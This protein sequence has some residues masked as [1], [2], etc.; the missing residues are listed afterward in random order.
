MAFPVQRVQLPE[1][2]QVPPPLMMSDPASFAHHT[3]TTRWPAVV[4]RIL[5]END[6]E[7]PTVARLQQLCRDLFSGTV[8]SLQDEDAPDW[9]DWEQDLLPYLGL[10]WAE[11]PWLFA[12][13]YFYRRILEAV[14]YFSG[15]V[16]PFAS[17]K[18]AAL[19]DAARAAAQPAAPVAQSL[20]GALWGNRADLSLNPEQLWRQES[21]A[22]VDRILADRILA[23]RILVDR[24]E[25][26][27]AY[28]QAPGGSSS[29]RIRI[30]IVA[31]NA[32]A[33]LLS[34]LALAASLLKARPDAQ[35]K[36]HLK[37]YP[38]FVSDATL[39]DAAQTLAAIADTPLGAEL[40]PHLSQGVLKLQD[41]PLWNRPLA[42]W[43][44][45]EPLSAIFKG[46]RLVIL[47]GDANYRRLLGDCQW[48][49]TA[50]F[51]RVSAYFP[52][53]VAALRTLKSELVVGLTAAQISHLDKV[54]GLD[55]AHERWMTAGEWGVIQARLE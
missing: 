25:A 24:T 5:K 40:K 38:T 3:Y 15:D 8:R 12:E 32:G 18:Q 19:R 52:S 29:R 46:S 27:A 37:A 30:D 51:S 23:D 13:F 1:I 9:A 11:V 33:E 28:L 54:H 53:A 10:P 44:L 6:F 26:I 55:V 36:I 35:V 2:S 31:D 14:A 16:D 21:P 4:E 45:Q 43:Q 47:K 49:P 34:D 22:P 7:A 42:F 20:Y 48:S 50:H 39:A 41:S 17:Q